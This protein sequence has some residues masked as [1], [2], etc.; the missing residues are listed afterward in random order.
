[1]LNIAGLKLPM[2]GGMLVTGNVYFVD[3]GATGASDSNDG[4]RPDRGHAC[5][6][7]EGAYDK[8]TASNGDIVV[9]MPGHAETVTAAVAFD[10]AGITVIGVGN[11]S[12]RPN[13]TSG[14]TGSL[15]MIEISAANVTIENIMFTG[16]TGG[17]N[18]PFIDVQAVDYITIRGCIFYQNTKQLDAITVAGPSVDY[19]VIEDCQF[20]GVDAGADN[21]ILFEDITNST[22]NLNPI[23][24][25]CY[26][27]YTRASGVDDSAI[28]FSHSSG[29]TM[30]I[31][32]EDCFCMGLADGDAFVNPMGQAAT[33][34]SGLINECRIVTAD[35]TDWLQV[36][37]SNISIINTYAAE[38]AT[39]SGATTP[40]AEIWP[41]ATPAY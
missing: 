33:R 31:L 13:L 37:D 34:V 4:L 35:Q 23:I 17:T 8:C 22:S 16:S 27:D 14:T 18:E 1:M 25:K 6:T 19:L 7:I 36:T 39:R 24:R 29:S 12:N 11:G 20:I 26:F 40:L 5:A 32:I 21:S 41:S 30:G 10:T 3:S 38:P 2:I 28:C 15:N 9:A